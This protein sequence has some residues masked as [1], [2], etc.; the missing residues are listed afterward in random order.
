M[1]LQKIIKLVAAIV[2]VISIFFLVRII[3]AG[4]E[5]LETDPALQDSIVSPFMYIAYIILGVMVFLVLVFSIKHMFT[6]AATLK[7]TL[8][9]VGA[10]LALALIAYFGFAT[11]VETPLRDGEVLSAGD[12]QLVGAGLYLFYFLVFIAVGIMLFTG[13]KK[14]VK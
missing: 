5:A 9:N 1:N 3:G 6:N 13:I 7:K 12:S 10:F 11:G 14:M 2:G 8:T 4:D